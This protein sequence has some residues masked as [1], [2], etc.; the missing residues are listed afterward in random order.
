M[1]RFIDYERFT[2]LGGKLNLDETK[3]YMYKK[4]R[5]NIIKGGT[6]RVDLS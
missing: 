2:L 5:R 4:E 3:Y 1:D 6:K